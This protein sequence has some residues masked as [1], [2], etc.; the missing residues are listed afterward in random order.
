MNLFNEAEWNQFRAD[1]PGMSFWQ[2]M[3]EYLYVEKILVR[4][5]EEEEV[6]YEN[7]FFWTDDK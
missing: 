2:A 7:T 1:H 5:T 6:I 3:R 4:Y